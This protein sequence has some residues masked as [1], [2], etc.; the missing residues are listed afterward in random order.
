MA[1]IIFIDIKGVTRTV[2]QTADDAAYSILDRGGDTAVVRCL[3]FAKWIK[4]VMN[5]GAAGTHRR[6]LWFTA[7]I[8][9]VQFSGCWKIYAERLRPEI[10]KLH[11]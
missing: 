6:H 4:G 5:S 7:H 10:P 3:L 11:G 1:L 8:S 2:Y 9:Q